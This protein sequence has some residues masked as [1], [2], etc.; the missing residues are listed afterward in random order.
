M[1]PTTRANTTASTTANITAVTLTGS[2]TA[3][4]KIYDGTTAASIATRSLNGVIGS[5]DVSLSGG[6]AAFASKAVGTAK[7]VTAT[8]LSLSGLDAGN[9]QLASSSATATADITARTLTVSATGVNKVYDG[10]SAATV[11]LSGQPVAGDS[12]TAQLRQRAASPTRTSAPAKTVNVSGIAVSGSRCG[13][14]LGQYHRDHDCGHHW[15]HA[16]DRSGTGVNKIYDGTTTAT[17]T[18]S[19]DRLSRR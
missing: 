10:T 4:N 11:T 7:T 15:A 13:Q 3:N 16:R 6:T 2:I 17:V 18:L 1:R 9:Y 5:D 12:L 19:D 8:G 14:L